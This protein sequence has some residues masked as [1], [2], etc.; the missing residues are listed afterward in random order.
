[1]GKTDIDKKIVAVLVEEMPKI[2]KTRLNAKMQFKNLPPPELT[3]KKV[4]E[5]ALKALENMW[6]R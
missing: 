6:K 1:M 5:M 3:T 2:S 4:S